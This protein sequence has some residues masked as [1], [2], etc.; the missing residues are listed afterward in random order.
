MNCWTCSD[1][2]AAAA[3]AV[4]AAAAWWD[5]DPAMTSLGRVASYPYRLAAAAAAAVVTSL[6]IGWQYS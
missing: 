6:T 3:A 5:F 1:T 4:V 2:A